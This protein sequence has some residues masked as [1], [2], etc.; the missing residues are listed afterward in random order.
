[1]TIPKKISKRNR[2]GLIVLIFLLALIIMLPRAYG[3]VRG[4]EQIIVSVKE[5]DEG[6]DQLKSQQ[7]SYKSK[8]GKASKYKAPKSKFNPNDYGQK[9]WMALGLSEKQANVVV[10]FAARGIKNNDQLRQIF[11]I[12]DELFALIEDSTFYPVVDYSKTHI[13]SLKAKITGTKANLQLNLNTATEEELQQLSG[14]GKHYS[15]KIVEY[16][17]KL[18]GFVNKEQLLEIWKFDEEKLDKIRPNISVSGT[19]K[20]ININ[21]CTTEQLAKHPYFNWNIANS[22]VKMRTKFTKYTSIDQLLQSELISKELLEKI[23]PY[24]ILEE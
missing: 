7:K 19:V 14:I 20:K 12:N 3:W 24:L 16:R 18:G 13:D 11:V 9:D 22:I 1:M 4:D 17:E 10:K 6:V 15:Q 8:S 21:T 23:K 5:M 2:R